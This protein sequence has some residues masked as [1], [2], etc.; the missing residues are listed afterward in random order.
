MKQLMAFSKETNYKKKIFKKE[1][2]VTDFLAITNI[3]DI[4]NIKLFMTSD[5]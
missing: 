2:K 3:I 5:A 1:E 4:L